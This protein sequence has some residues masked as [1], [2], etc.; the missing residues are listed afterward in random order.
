M[1][2]PIYST[3]PVLTAKWLYAMSDG[4]YNGFLLRLKDEVETIFATPR[5][6]RSSNDDVKKALLSTYDNLKLADRSILADCKYISYI[7]KTA[8]KKLDKCSK[9]NTVK[10]NY[11]APFMTG[12]H[13]YLDDTDSMVSDLLYKQGR[14]PIGSYAVQSPKIAPAIES[15]FSEQTAYAFPNLEHY[16]KTNYGLLLS[17]KKLDLNVEEAYIINQ[18]SD[19]YVPTLKQN[20]LALVGAS[21]ATRQNAEKEFIRQLDYMS[22]EIERIQEEHHART[23]D[24]I[25]A[26]TMFFASQSALTNSDSMLSLATIGNKR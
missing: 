23:L 7:I 5:L 8:R 14:S 20:A 18:I 11:V 22:S 10:R 24:G 2:I 25:Q 12:I 17:V 13:I 6:D 4:A 9:Y 21:S 16:F 3:V 15:N 26:Q 19:S 1:S